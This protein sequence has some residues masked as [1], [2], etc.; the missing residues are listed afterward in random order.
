MS[1]IFKGVKIN[2]RAGFGPLNFAPT[3][4]VTPDT[5]SINEGDAVT[6]NVATTNVP[7]GTTLYWTTTG[8]VAAADFLDSTMSGSF[9]ITSGAGVITRTLS[10]D[11]STEGIENFSI[12]I[13]TDSTIGAIVAS[14]TSISIG[15]ISQTPTYTITPDSISIN[16]GDTVTLNI[17][18]TDVPH[19]TTLYWTI[20]GTATAADFSDSLTSGSFT[21][22][23]GAGV[24]TRTLSNDLMTEG[25][26]NMYVHI[27]TG[28]TSGTVVA[29]TSMI[30]I[31]DT[32]LTPTDPVFN[33]VSLLINGNGTDG[34]QNNTFIDSSTSALTIT[35]NGN[36]TQGS[37]TPFSPSGW[38]MSFPAGD[39]SIVAPSN[40]V[41]AFG[42]G[43]FCVE[44]WV[45]LTVN[46]GGQHL[47]FGNA[48]ATTTVGFGVNNGY[49]T[50]S[51]SAAG[52]GAATVGQLVAGQWYHVAYTRQGTTLRYFVDGVTVRTGTNSTNITA[53]AFN[54]GSA[55]AGQSLEGQLS[56]V[57][58][59]KGSARYTADF[60][61]PTSPLPQIANTALLTAQDNRFKD[62]STNNFTLT[63]TGTVSVVAS[64]PFKSG[65]EYLPS[66]NGASM[67]FD[68]TGDYL[69]AP[70]PGSLSS[71]FTIEC[72]VYET[73][74]AAGYGS[75][76]SLGSYT[77]GIMLRVGAGAG[78]YSDLFF[79]GTVIGS[80]P[81][82]Y[83]PLNA[84][85]HLAIV[86]SGSATGNIK[87]YVN[88]VLRMT[89]SSALT[90][91]INAG[92]TVGS[93]EFAQAFNG[94]I[95]DFRIN[96]G[97]AVYTANFTP[98]TAP[99][100]AITNTALLLNGANAGIVDAS[101]KTNIETVG[102]AQISTTQQKYGSGSVY[103]DGTGDYL[104]T[105]N[106]QFGYNN[107]T[108]EGWFRPASIAATTNFWGMGNGSGSVPKFSLYINASG[109][110]V[111]DTGS[112]TPQ[113]PLSAVSA[114]S[115]INLN[116]WNHIALVRSGTGAGQTKLYVNGTSV[117]SGALTGNLNT[118]TGK[119]HIG[120]I[121]EAFG[122]R[123]NGHIDD[124]RITPGVARYTATFTPPTT[125]MPVQ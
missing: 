2:G 108:I 87:F 34:T 4:L 52:L 124:F 100:T 60:T 69:T 46:D 42:T 27:R 120:R 81:G 95:A 65:V 12:D 104:V 72:W 118:I 39:N 102:N 79:N 5:T 57:R 56:N 68:G 94:Y 64:S 115:V 20:S 89:S 33:Y 44:G 28:S 110:L 71:N 37:F 122:L 31:G 83:V 43:D 59:L 7:N 55:I 98:P 21:I 63:T 10:S 3:Y 49:L 92:L 117:A 66:V 82:Q 14:S 35:R 50:A 22:N 112:I 62:N 41:F 75:V 77:A 116:N 61:V 48:N 23:A 11:F 58:V 74:K 19:G 121:G 47:F 97:T 99:L 107:F 9:T 36:T 32:S 119:M 1:I 67:Q 80:D 103:L 54:V 106:Y 53:A 86:R 70:T 85:T 88:G 109:N 8:T 51:T 90:A 91:T 24:I 111:V 18:T 113:Y 26:E 105:D 93:N 38:S 15:D 17:T 78:A 40:A 45:K 114:A 6:F 101:S 125:G 25:T 96:N 123:Y 30:V 16:E 29:L 84:W 73:S 76:F 13:R